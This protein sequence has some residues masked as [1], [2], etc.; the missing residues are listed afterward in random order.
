MS[1]QDL[2][3]Y[4]PTDPHGDEEHEP[5]VIVRV[6]YLMSREQLSTV[7]GMAWAEIAGDREPESLTVAEVRHEVEAWLSV[8]AFFEIDNQMERDQQRTFPLHQQRILQVLAD[9]VQQAYPP[10]RESAPHRAQDPRYSEGTVTLLTSDRGEVTIEEPA[11]CIGHGGDMVGTLDE[12]AHNGAEI[13]VPFVTA[14]NAPSTIMTAQLSHA[15]YLTLAPEPFPV[16]YVELDEHCDLDVPDGR[17]LSRALRLA[18]VRLDR[19]LD[20][21]ARLRGGS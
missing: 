12:I 13:T 3:V 9:T 14:R 19:A 4:G 6:D 16:L 17:N 7:L 18:A 2:P 11:W 8:Q 1:I 10:R 21:L 15:P 20:D 5:D